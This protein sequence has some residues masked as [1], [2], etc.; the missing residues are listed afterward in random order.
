M[1][2]AVRG[3]ERWTYVRVGAR[4]TSGRVVVGLDFE[5]WKEG[6]ETVFCYRTT[7]V[8][9]GHGEGEGGGMPRI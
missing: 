4:A 9:W 6:G 1:G 5:G 8:G 2:K 3:G 7:R